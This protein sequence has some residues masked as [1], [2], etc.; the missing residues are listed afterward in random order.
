M[1]FESL[2]KDMKAPGTQP[3]AHG[4]NLEDGSDGANYKSILQFP[5][6]PEFLPLFKEILKV[7]GDLCYKVS[8][9]SS[10]LE[11]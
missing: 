3:E 11:M 8:L 7:L 2:V 9:S 10:I 1:F 5:E 6:A 4:N